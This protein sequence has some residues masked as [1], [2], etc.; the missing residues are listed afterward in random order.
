[1]STKYR[2]VPGEPPEGTLT[3]GVVYHMLHEKAVRVAFAECGLEPPRALGYVV[4][5]EDESEI[6]EE[7]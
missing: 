7:A 5:D 3:L 6:E 2:Y 4:V 1:M